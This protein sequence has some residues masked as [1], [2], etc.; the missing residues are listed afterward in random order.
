MMILISGQ[1]GN[2]KTLK[3]MELMRA[4]YERNAQAVKEGKEEP[5]RFFTNIAGATREEN[6]EAF[7]WV[8]AIPFAESEDTPPERRKPDWRLCPDGSYVL[9]DEAHA[10]GNTEGLE[11]YGILFPGT[12][13]P[14]ESDDPRIRAMSTH[15]HRGFDL[16][17]M[18]QWPNKIHHNVRTLV[19]E[20]HH[21]NRA[22]GLQRA[23]V[24]KWTRVQPDPYDEKARDKA[25][26]EIWTYPKDLYNRYKSATL[27]T[28]TYKFKIP[29]KVWSAVSM[30]VVGMVMCYVIYNGFL[31]PDLP[32]KG[33]KAAEGTQASASLL[34]PASPEPH[35][36]SELFPGTGAYH[37]VNTAAAPTV[38]GC[39]SSDRSCRCFNTDGFQIDMSRK[40]CEALLDKPLPFNIYHQYSTSAG[41]GGAL[42]GGGVAPT[43]TAFSG[44]TIN[45]PQV[46]GYGDIGVGKA[47]SAP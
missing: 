45:A 46:S 33:A 7:P 9:F 30:L 38:A 36:A 5:R 12:G 26:E 37:S 42:A 16:V 1:P 39:V 8:E 3:A 2:G 27:H 32:Q 17:F 14:G 28:A 21:M 13:K 47:S 34:A 22:M 19:G 31:K 24:V 18:T 35:P 29:K 11:R 20:H 6:P 44:A 4:E 23:G 43:D 40:E 25:E 10:D 15:R 41:V